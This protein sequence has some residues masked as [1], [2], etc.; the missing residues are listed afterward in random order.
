VSPRALGWLHNE[1][2][3]FANEAAPGSDPARPGWTTV[4]MPIE[5]IEHGA[6]RLLSYGA[7]VEV[8]APPALRQRLLDEL[9]ATRARYADE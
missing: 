5:S 8:I 7:E 9:S 1:R 4:L 2:I 3:P 6:R